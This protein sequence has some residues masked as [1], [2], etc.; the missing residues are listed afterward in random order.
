MCLAE[1]MRVHMADGVSREISAVKIGDQI[2]DEQ[3][4]FGFVTN[5]FSGTEEFVYCIELSNG[6]VLK[7]TKDHP[8]LTENGFKR[9]ED[10]K[11]GDIVQCAVGSIPLRALKCANMRAWFIILSS[12]LKALR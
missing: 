11:S 12:T 10:L 9:M 4:G 8:V 6:G 7:A 2:L 1:N 3:G 5:V